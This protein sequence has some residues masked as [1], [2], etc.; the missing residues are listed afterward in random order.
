MSD[1]AKT[2]TLP[3]ALYVVATPIGNIED[4]SGRAKTVLASV[5]CILA[6]DTRVTGQL[7]SQLGIKVRMISFNA[8]SEEGKSTRV[9]DAIQSGQSLALVSDA[10]TPA[11]SDP[12]R[13]VVAA[14]HQAGLSIVPIPG[15]SALST[16]LSVSGLPASPSHFLGFLPAKGGARKAALDEALALPGTVIL[17]EA[18]HRIIDLAKRLDES[19]NGRLVVFARELTKTFEQVIHVSAGQCEA[20]CVENPDRIRGEFVVLV[21]PGIETGG[22]TGLDAAQLLR[23]LSRELPPSRAAAVAA[24]LTGVPKKE[25]YRRLTGETEG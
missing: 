3:P 11:I 8:H 18:P 20:W 21:G 1:I 9:I 12:G 16:A 24:E 22:K 4:L 15:V 7:L 23:V 13:L 17:Y 5:D 2:P 14:C 6:E 25:L 19:A 10:G